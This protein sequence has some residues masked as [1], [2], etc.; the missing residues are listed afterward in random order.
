MSVIYL[1]RHGQASMGRSNYDNLSDKGLR[2]S[3]ILA[4]SFRRRVEEINIIQMGHLQRHKQTYEGFKSKFRTDANV[5]T[6]KGW[7]E[8]DHVEIIEAFNPRYKRKWYMVAD[9]VR[10]FNPKREFIK[11]FD[12][13]MARWMS[14]EYDDDYTESWSHFRNRCNKSMHEL[15]NELGENKTGM[16]FTSGG[17]ISAVTQNLLD[18]SDDYFMRFNK[19]IVNCSVT[20]VVKGKED[21]FLSTLNDYNHFEHD[22]EL[23]TYI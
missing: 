19:K 11:M 4:K 1:I 12:K 18:L 3:E 14:G 20:K 15:F 5:S 16:V 10:K 8:Y 23:I 9:M 17:V 21:T 2:Q 7:N 13:S 6:H 22:R